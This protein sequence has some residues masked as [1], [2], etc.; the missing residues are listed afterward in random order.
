MKRE[1]DL[2]GNL[3]EAA[4]TSR[5]GVPLTCASN[6]GPAAAYRK[7][8]FLYRILETPGGGEMGIV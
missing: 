5:C 1:E 3:G 7:N 8:V 2:E 4:L 6:D